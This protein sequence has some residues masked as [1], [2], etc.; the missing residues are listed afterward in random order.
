MEGGE[1]EKQLAQNQKGLG[2]QKERVL[3]VTWI[4]RTR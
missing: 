4:V 2:L 3:K 1:R